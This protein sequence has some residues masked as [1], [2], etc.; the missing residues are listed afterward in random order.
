MTTGGYREE[1]LNVIL[2]QLLDEQGIVSA[3]E[4][5]IRDAMRRRSMPDVIVSYQ[6]LRTVI[7]G[8][9]EDHP[10]ARADA[11]G[12]AKERIERGIAHI[13]IAVIYPSELRGVEFHDLKAA[14]SQA[15]LNVDVCTEAGDLGWTEGNA[16][17]LGSLLRR[18]FESLV[19]EDVLKEAVSTL[20]EGIEIFAT[21]TLPKPGIV[22]RLA[23]A[24]GIE[25]SGLGEELAE[26]EEEAG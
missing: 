12:D 17:Y 15:T 2:A 14:L 23:K 20:N 11:L 3:P 6:G 1:V 4:Q 5:S 19:R 7:E 13:G 25:V 10:L 22:N 16:M 8:K 26:P 9:V 24:L 21:A 18:A